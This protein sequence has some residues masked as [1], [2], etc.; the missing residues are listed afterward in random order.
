MATLGNLG[1]GSMTDDEILWQN[2]L[3]A[4]LTGDQWKNKRP[5]SLNDSEISEIITDL[6]DMARATGVET[7]VQTVKA[8]IKH[9]VAAQNK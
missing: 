5:E 8:A 2:S 6:A 1:V 7:N 9:I 4:I 3:L